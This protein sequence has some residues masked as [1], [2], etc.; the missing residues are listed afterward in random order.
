MLS[1]LMVFFRWECGM[2]VGRRLGMVGVLR[3]GGGGRES[4]APVLAN[5]S[6]FSLP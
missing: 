6:A 1:C 5:T 4:D 3:L 2:G